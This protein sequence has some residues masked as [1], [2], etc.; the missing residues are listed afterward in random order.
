MG[1]KVTTDNFTYDLALKK[2][3]YLCP[4]HLYLFYGWNNGFFPNFFLR[5]AAQ[6]LCYCTRSV[7]SSGLGEEA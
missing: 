4:L 6:N 1:L 5:V 7:L 2:F 3:S